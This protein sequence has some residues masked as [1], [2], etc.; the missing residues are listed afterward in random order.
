MHIARAPLTAELPAPP[1]PDNLPVENELPPLQ[2][3]SAPADDA[4]LF[5]QSSE[6]APGFVTTEYAV[7]S[8]MPP[9]DEAD[10]ARTIRMADLFASEGSVDEARS[11][12]EDLLARD[13]NNESIRTKL[14]ALTPPAAE[15]ASDESKEK[16]AKLENWLARV[17]RGEVG[18]V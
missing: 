15:P 17:K 3:P 8:S 18:R 5:A 10:F 11:I 9:L 7:T 14:D 6:I 13:P 16:V 2:E 4:D 12:Y 1:L